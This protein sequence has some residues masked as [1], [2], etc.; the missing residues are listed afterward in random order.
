MIPLY[1]GIDA[2]G[3]KTRLLAR[4]AGSAQALQL[5]ATGANLL[6]HGEDHV[7]RLF[8]RLVRQAQ[9]SYPGHS[10]GAV[11]A[12]VAGAGETRAQR[13]LSGRIRGLLG[14]IPVLEI[15]HDGVIA[16]EAAFPGESGMLLIAG[17]GSAVLARTA[18]GVFTRA[19][20]W[21]YLFGDEG[22]GYAI[23]R[24]GLAAIAHALD[25]GPATLLCDLVQDRHGIRGRHALLKGVSSGRLPIQHM[26]PSVLT[27]AEAGD[28]VAQDIVGEEVLALAWQARWLQQRTPDISPRICPTGGMIRSSY[29]LESLARTL[30]GMLPGFRLCRQAQPS[31]V[32]AVTFAMQLAEGAVEPAALRVTG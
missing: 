3:S 30:Q 28:T 14:A 2:G 13:S 21:G 15:V 16:L 18:G 29:Y 25:G 4:T 32:G 7:A 12:G 26:A 5:K 17:T 31:T 9:Q 8:A 20:G 19:G 11:V 23:G 24:R 1:I 10:L 6:R 27:A 22:S